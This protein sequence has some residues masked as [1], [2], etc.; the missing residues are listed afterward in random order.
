MKNRKLRTIYAA[1]I[2]L[3]I[4]PGSPFGDP[5]K[6]GGPAEGIPDLN[7]PSLLEYINRLNP[8]DDGVILEEFELVPVPADTVPGFWEVGG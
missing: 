6:P 3:A 8:P 7:L 4:L 1:L 5:P 2:V